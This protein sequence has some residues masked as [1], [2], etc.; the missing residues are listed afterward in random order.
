MGEIICNWHL[1]LTYDDGKE[2]CR[3]HLGSEDE[4]EYTMEDEEKEAAELG[5]TIVSHQGIKC[6]ADN[7]STYGGHLD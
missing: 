7:D 2:I 1:H 3:T 4:I 6:E 5:R